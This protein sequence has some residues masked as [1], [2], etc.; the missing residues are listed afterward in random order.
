MPP[1]ALRRRNAPRP[2]TLIRNR[3]ARRDAPWTPAQHAILND[4]ALAEARAAISGWP[5]YAPT[6]LV[7]L[8]GLAA[9][10]GVGAIWWKDEGPRFGLGS[11]K[12][13]GGAYAVAR[14]LDRAAEA[15]GRPVAMEEIVSGRG[16]VAR[17]VTVCCATDGDH[18]RSVA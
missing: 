9:E 11:F 14:V 15:E 12:A 5:G 18:G 6:L 13:L 10:A 4:A 16:E 2:F 3:L 7:A 8:P 17:R 1:D